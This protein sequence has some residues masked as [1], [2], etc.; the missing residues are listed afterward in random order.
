MNNS[1][2]INRILIVLFLFGLFFG[3]PTAKAQV[4]IE[5]SAEKV[6][7]GGKEYYMHHVKSGQ[8]LGAIS[9]VYQVSV[10]EIERL[11]PEVKEGL[12]TGLVIGIPVRP[13]PAPK[14]EPI[15]GQT[16]GA[17][18]EPI[19]NNIQI[20]TPQKE[21]KINS[22][23]KAGIDKQYA[24]IERSKEITKIGGKQYYFKGLYCHHRGHRTT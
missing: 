22:E 24:E 5:R 3:L 17:P 14:V 12:K 21:H 20:E 9:Q 7:V 16:E 4:Q 8:T 15:E 18:K 1:M 13:L 2:K 6:K 23:E 11:N 19:D 10:E